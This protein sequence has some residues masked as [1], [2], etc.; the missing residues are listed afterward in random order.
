MRAGQVVLTGDLHGADQC[1][2]LALQP[3]F[4]IRSA[5]SDILPQGSMD[6]NPFPAGGGVST[7][8]KQ[9]KIGG[10]LD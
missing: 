7:M 6:I 3:Y 9:Q 1:A 4:P 8:Q 2:R 5:F 10:K